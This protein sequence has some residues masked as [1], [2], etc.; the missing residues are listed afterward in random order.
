[1]TP[2]FSVTST[3]HF[4]RLFRRLLRG[5]PDLRDLRDSI[6]EILSADP[7]NRTRRYHIQKLEGVSQGDGQYR[8]SM[9]RFRFRY[10]IYGRDVLLQRC[11]LRRENTYR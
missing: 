11:S 7:Y 4:E 10:D 2:P 3:P 8:L 6:E 9:G 5:H 1:M